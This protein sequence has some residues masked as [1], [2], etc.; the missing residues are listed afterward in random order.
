[1]ILI[2]YFILCNRVFITQ[3]RTWNEDDCK[4]GGDKVCTSEC[5]HPLKYIHWYSYCFI[6]Y[7]V[8]SI[9][10]MVVLIGNIMK[11]P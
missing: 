4:D 7:I 11:T 10:R 6:L 9:W 1:M 3:N 2:L 5:V 8:N